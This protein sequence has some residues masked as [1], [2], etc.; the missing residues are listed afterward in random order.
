MNSYKLR[1]F[2]SRSTAKVTPKL[3]SLC[4][5][6]QFCLIPSSDHNYHQL[7]SISPSLSCALEIFYLPQTLVKY[8]DYSSHW[9][10][11]LHCC[12]NK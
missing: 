9:F 4:R 8:K 5:L 3:K 12:I 2:N 11:S 10:R 1:V 7:P 6:P